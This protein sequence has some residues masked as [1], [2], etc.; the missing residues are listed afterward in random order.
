M[1]QALQPLIAERNLHLMLS[2]QPSGAISVYVEPCK[3][4]DG[5][6]DAF[7]SPFRVTA[8]AQELDDQLAVV[9]TQ[10]VAARKVTTTTL[11]Q[12]LAEAEAAQATAVAASKAK[13]ADKNKKAATATTPGKATAK[14][15][16]AKQHTPSL[17]D[18]LAAP[19]A[20]IVPP[21][22]AATPSVQPV[23]A[24]LV[25]VVVSS[26]PIEEPV[27]V[28]EIPPEEPAASPVAETQVAASVATETEVM[29]L[30]A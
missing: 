28:E 14:V 7:V 2:I 15:E 3:T 12:S 19:S 29:D 13:M 9:L 20:A 16:P 11:A 27:V 10:W 17:L 30:F 21:A 6:D 5:E 4:K 18:D 26:T 1:F 8:T 24:D 22:P 25:P 23:A